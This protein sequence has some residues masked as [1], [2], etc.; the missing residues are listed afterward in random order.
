MLAGG[1]VPVRDVA[2]TEH[3]W[4]KSIRWANWRF[5]HYQREM[6]DGQDVGELYDIEADR[7]EQTNLSTARTTR[8]WWPSAAAGCSNG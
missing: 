7:Y 4:S 8:T 5:V 6:Y 1:S 2:V 3:V